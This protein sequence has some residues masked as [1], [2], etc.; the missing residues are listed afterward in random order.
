MK[1]LL[2]LCGMSKSPL[3]FETRNTVNLS[4]AESESNVGRDDARI[5][6]NTEL[7]YGKNFLL[8]GDGPPKQASSIILPYQPIDGH[9]FGAINNPHQRV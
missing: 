1:R 6:S 9:S 8:F 2:I 4:V 7:C 5:R 3:S